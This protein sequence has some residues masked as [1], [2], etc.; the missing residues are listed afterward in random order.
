MTNLEIL[1]F[2][3]SLLVDSGVDFASDRYILFGQ[4]DILEFVDIL[5]NGLGKGFSLEF[6]VLF[7]FDE[8]L[9]KKDNLVGIPLSKLG[10]E[11]CVTNFTSLIKSFY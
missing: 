11:D 10:N 9:F 6:S 7:Y 5:G 4:D 8:G 1:K 3:V 2:G